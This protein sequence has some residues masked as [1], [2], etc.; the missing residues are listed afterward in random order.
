MVGFLCLACRK[1]DDPVQNID[2]IL[3]IYIDSAGQDM[4]NTNLPG[5]YTNIRMNDVNGLTDAAPV[6]FTLKKDADTIN[7]IEYLAGARRVGTDST[8]NV[9]IYESKIALILNKKI[10]DSTMATVNDTMTLQYHATPELFQISKG[11]YNNVLRFT[12]VAGAPNV[13]RIVK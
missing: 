1:D 6:N 11:W 13:V 7:Y 4:L 12:K 5:G 3:Q 10:N 9:K 2:Q 8:Q